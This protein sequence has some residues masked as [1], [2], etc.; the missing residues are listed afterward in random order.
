MAFATLPPP[1]NWL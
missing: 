1:I